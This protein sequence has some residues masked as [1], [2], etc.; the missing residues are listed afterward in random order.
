MEIGN[1]DRGVVV[2]GRVNVPCGQR[3]LAHS[4]SVMAI[5]N[6]TMTKKIGSSL[7]PHPSFEYGQWCD[8]NSCV[9]G[10]RVYSIQVMRYEDVQQTAAVVCNCR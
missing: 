10:A 8:L 4:S 1:L 9:Q 5:T 2:G 3:I 6:Y 7:G